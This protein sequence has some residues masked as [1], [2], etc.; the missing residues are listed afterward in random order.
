MHGTTPVPPVVAF[1]VDRPE[2]LDWRDEVFDSAGIESFGTNVA[3]DIAAEP[4]LP[5]LKAAG[6]TTDAPAFITWLGVTMYLPAEAARRSLVELSELPARS[7][8]IFDFILPPDQRDAAGQSYASAVAAV[9][10]R[11]GEPWA[12]TA[13]VDDVTT[14]LTDAGLGRCPVR[15]A[16]R[17]IAVRSVGASRPPR[18][19]PPGRTCT[20]YSLVR[21][22]D[23]G[24]R[25]CI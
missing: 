25:I 10:G 3:C 16:G 6:L 13:S 7:Q 24:E 18:P 22:P 12:I 17:R 21:Q 15:A 8:L 2:T 23:G 11:N 9:T 20:R 19:A 4:L 14:W 1:H 5:A